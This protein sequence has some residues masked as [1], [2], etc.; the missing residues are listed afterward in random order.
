MPEYKRIAV[1]EL[2]TFVRNPRRGDVRAIVESLTR[3]G[4]YRPIVVNAGSLTGGLMRCW[5][6]ITR[7][8]R[9]GR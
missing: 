1:G 6:G 2:Q 7:C 9:R 8:W 5:R 4:Q 3:H